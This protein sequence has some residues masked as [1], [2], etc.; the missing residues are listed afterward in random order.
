L[1]S[2]F[3][4]STVSQVGQRLLGKLIK[5][6]VLRITFDL[7]IPR[8]RIVFGKPRAERRKFIRPE[9]T[10]RSFDLCESLH[11]AIRG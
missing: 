8:I 10:D 1:L 6:T 4:A 7:L 3:R 2:Q 11:L 9:A 5:S